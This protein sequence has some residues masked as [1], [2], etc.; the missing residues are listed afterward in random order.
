M[1]F[2]DKRYYA[3]KCKEMMGKVAVSALFSLLVLS[4]FVMA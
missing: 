4:I 3:N 1:Y 2:K